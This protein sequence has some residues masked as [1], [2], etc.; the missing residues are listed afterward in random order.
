MATHFSSSTMFC[1][2]FL[3]FCGSGSESSG[4]SFFCVHCC[5]PGVGVKVMGFFTYDLLVSKANDRNQTQVIR[6]S[7]CACVD[8]YQTIRSEPVMS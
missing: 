7:L 6:T 5:T 1:M 8:G 4:S 3:L 2:S